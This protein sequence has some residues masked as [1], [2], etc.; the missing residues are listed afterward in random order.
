[1]LTVETLNAGVVEAIED[2]PAESWSVVVTTI[3]RSPRWRQALLPQRFEFSACESV[4]V[5][6]YVA[7]SMM[8]WM[9]GAVVKGRVARAA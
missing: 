6:R 9:I 4:T 5:H 3:F 7:R 1:V 8:P 2:V